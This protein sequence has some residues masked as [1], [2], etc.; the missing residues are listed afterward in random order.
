M[1]DKQERLNKLLSELPAQFGAAME[2]E[3]EFQAWCAE[4]KLGLLPDFARRF[5]VFVEASEPYAKAYREIEAKFPTA[6]ERVNDLLLPIQR[7]YF[8]DC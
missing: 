2:A 5:A 4:N 3:L 1:S 7:E 8:G 6:I